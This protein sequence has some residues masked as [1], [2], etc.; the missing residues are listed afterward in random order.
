MVYIW[1]AG[2]LRCSLL[3]GHFI[4]LS[5]SI[6]VF[7]T[8][9]SDSY[10]VDIS[11]EQRRQFK[12]EVSLALA[13][14]VDG[15]SLRCDKASPYLLLLLLTRPLHVVKPSFLSF[16]IDADIWAESFWYI[17]LVSI[18]AAKIAISAPDHEH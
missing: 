3:S 5:P 10:V 17:H 6:H 12:Y 4:D 18:W 16:N 9:V 14:H 15:V 11:L 1:H 13:R 2:S 8:W 7:C